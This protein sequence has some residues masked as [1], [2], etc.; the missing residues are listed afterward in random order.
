MI[1]VKNLV[2]RYDK[3]TAVDHINFTIEKGKIYGFLGPNGAGKSTTMNMITGY[4]APTEGEI[5]ING[6]DIMLDP[7][8]AKA[9]LGYLPEIPPLYTEMTVMEYLKFVAG[10]KAIPKA[11]RKKAITDALFMTKTK[12]V[13][14]RLIRN[15]S[16]GYKQ[17]VGLAQA[18]LGMPEIIILDEPTVGLDP[19]QIIEMRELIRTLALNHT[20]ILS[21]HIMQEI[22]A[23]CDHV[24]II[25]EGKIVA[26]DSTE[27][28][29]RMFSENEV[30]DLEIKGEPQAIKNALTGAIEEGKVH[31]QP[32]EFKKGIATIRIITPLGTDVREKVFNTCSR[33]KM[34][35]VS[36]ILKTPT[37]EEIFIELVNKKTIL[38]TLQ[39]EKIEDTSEV[40]SEELA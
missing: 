39:Q 26:N 6:Y 38:P 4:V 33:L 27:N 20:V 40:E 25:S 3:L 18:I 21:S 15:L 17:R 30:L 37:L 31:L 34:P 13:Q 35:I 7:A 22:S 9:Q 1:Q 19:Q 5:I 23:V 8:Q 29:Q 24:I 36:M 14:N 10:L 16:K 12:E 28:I 2:K 32:D 11:E